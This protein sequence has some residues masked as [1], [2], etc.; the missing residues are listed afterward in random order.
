M[1]LGGRVERGGLGNKLDFYVEEYIGWEIFGFFCVE[2]SHLLLL[3]YYSKM[4]WVVFRYGFYIGNNVLDLLV[5]VPAMENLNRH[6]I[7]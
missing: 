5:I 4:G 7:I 3:I 6:P 2:F 1:E